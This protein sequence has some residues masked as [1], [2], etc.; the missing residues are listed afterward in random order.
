[1][2]QKTTAPYYVVANAI[3]DLQ[4]NVATHQK[5]VKGSERTPI[6]RMKTEIYYYS[7]TRIKETRIKETFGYKKRFHS[8][9]FM[10]ANFLR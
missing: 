2:V 8:S 5:C 9:D 3:Q 7:R 6:S 4:L 10:Q 1:M